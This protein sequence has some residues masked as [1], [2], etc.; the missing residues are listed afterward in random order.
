MDSYRVALVQRLR[1]L[2]SRQ[3]LAAHRGCISGPGICCYAR[4]RSER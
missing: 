4:D 3:G 2:Q 1:Q